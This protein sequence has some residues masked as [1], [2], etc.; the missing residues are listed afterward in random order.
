MTFLPIE[1]S[2]VS[3]RPLAEFGTV[4]LSRV[5]QAFANAAKEPQHVRDAE[6][7]REAARR[8]VDNLMR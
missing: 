4:L 6:L 2:R 5:R 3:S 1:K 7:R 8:A